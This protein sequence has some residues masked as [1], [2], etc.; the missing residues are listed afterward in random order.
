MVIP[1]DLTAVARIVGVRK[2][3]TIISAVTD[4][5]SRWE[6]FATEAGV[7]D[8]FYSEIA[9]ALRTDIVV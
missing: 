6:T 3:T 4:S 1:N 8:T 5:I 2:P 7:A 9:G